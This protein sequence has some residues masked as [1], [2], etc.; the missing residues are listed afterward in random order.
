MYLLRWLR[1]HGNG[2]IYLWND[3][4]TLQRVRSGLLLL[5]QW[6]ATGDVRY[7]LGSRGQLL[8]GWHDDRRGHDVP[9]GQLLRRRGGER[10]YVGGDVVVRVWRGAIGI[11][12]HWRACCEHDA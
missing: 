1:E 10:G 3:C 2:A 11:V 9:R 12:W 8:S 5:G 6:R 7:R 4:G